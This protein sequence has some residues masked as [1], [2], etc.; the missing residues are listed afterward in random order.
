MH[1]YEDYLLEALEAVCYQDVPEEGMQEAIVDQA[2]L[3]A[4]D[5]PDIYDSLQF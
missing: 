4:G 3:L 2:R 5:S 1:S